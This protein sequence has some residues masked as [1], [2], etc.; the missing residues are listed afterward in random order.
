MAF[1]GMDEESLGLILSG[2]G[3]GL[4]RFG[5]IRRVK[6]QQ[7]TQL[8]TREAEREAIL[9]RSMAIQTRIDERQRR[10]RLA[11]REETIRKEALTAGKE[12]VKGH[13]AARTAAR[14]AD[15][16]MLERG[17]TAEEKARETKRKEAVRTGKSGYRF[18]QWLQGKL[19]P[20]TPQEKKFF[21]T[22]AKG[23]TGKGKAP[24]KTKTLST[25][26]LFKMWMNFAPDKKMQ[27]QES[28]VT[29]FKDFA[30]YYQ[31][32][33]Q[34]GQ[35]WGGTPTVTPGPGTGQP[36][37]ATG[38]QPPPEPPQTGK[39]G[40]DLMNFYATQGAGDVAPEG[41]GEDENEPVYRSE[42]KK[43]AQKL[44]GF[45]DMP[46]VQQQMLIELYMME[47]KEQ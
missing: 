26:D 36:Q 6:K 42:A 20:A 46:V 19:E 28:G 35:R 8:Q 21:E 47:L 15:I 37:T 43:I 23:A 17:L 39:G 7:E 32:S 29:D 34:P 9:E 31:E 30:R 14:K 16:A 45:K 13:G 22:K 25:T 4:E 1:L 5:D 18:E 24:D 10:E 11:R 2:L 44:P 38:M 33:I 27:L 3:Q 40:L 12:E 41:V